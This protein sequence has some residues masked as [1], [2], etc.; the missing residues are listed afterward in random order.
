MNKKK[1]IIIGIAS[2]LIVFG[3]IFG[4]IYMKLAQYRH[5][6]IDRSDEALGIT[7][8]M[9]EPEEDMEEVRD[10]IVHIALFGVDRRNQKDLGRS[11]AM[12]IATLDFKHDKVKL[13]SLM[14]DIYV[15]IE[16]HGHTKLNHA[17]AYGGA[18]LAIKTINQNFGTDIRDYVTVDFFTLE[19]IID[20]IGGVELEVKEEEVPFINHFMGETARIQNKE[21]VPLLKGGVQRLNGMQAVSFARI[22]S[23]GNGDFERTDRQRQVLSAI[24]QEVKR[25]GSTAIPSLFLKISPHIETSLDQGTILSLGY[26]YFKHQPMELEQQRFPL[27]DEWD[28]LRVNG[29]W[30][31]NAHIE[32]MRERIQNYLYKDISPNEQEAYQAET[33]LVEANHLLGPY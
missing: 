20:A 18:E 25:Q 23:V 5:V 29:V 3:S 19:N 26:E 15:P 1:V 27:D 30:Y 32:K 24:L 7:E 17:Y 33:P 22:R 8:R 14:R 10:D 28:S 13:T 4:Y 16:G 21:V 6:E 11:D 31:M 9:P 12:L 2:F